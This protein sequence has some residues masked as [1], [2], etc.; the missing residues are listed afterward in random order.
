MRAALVIAC[1][2]L[3]TAGARAQ[4]ELRAPQER[5]SALADALA[6]ETAGELIVST[7]AERCS[8]EPAEIR[9]ICVEIT[10]EALHLLVQSPDGRSRDAALAPSATE[11]TVAIVAVS[12][13]TELSV[14]DA[15]PIA[16]YEQRLDGERPPR[17]VRDEHRADDPWR[18]I[19]QVGVGASL[20]TTGPA[21]SLGP[22]IA[23]AVGGEAPFGL[24]ILIGVD[25]TYPIAI[26]D[27][28]DLWFVRA[29]LSVG[30]RFD[31]FHVMARAGTGFTPQRYGDRSR[32][33][34]VALV[35]GGAGVGVS[36]SLG[37][38]DVLFMLGLEVMQRS[39]AARPIELVSSLQVVSEMR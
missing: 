24:R 37:S 20:V 14:S 28:T 7:P 11:R 17:A 35:S 38:A 15:P 19:G 21:S 5:L 13:L 29:G 10:G 12:L 23:F 27:E 3:G 25:G 18:V 8:G 4:I 36:V 26:Q 30:A 32:Y 22:T 2:C 33:A 1:V 6:L 31:W 34:A 9:A 16:Y 39:I